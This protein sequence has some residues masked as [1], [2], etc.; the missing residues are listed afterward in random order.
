MSISFSK[1]IIFCLF[2]ALCSLQLMAQEPPYERHF[3]DDFKS[4]YSSRK[5]NYEGDINV[6]NELRPT[7]GKFSEYKDM[8]PK[9]REENNSNSVQ[10]GGNVLTWIFV[11]ILIIAVIYVVYNVMDE[12]Q[13]GFFSRGKFRKINSQEINVNN[14]EETDLQALITSAEDQGD[15]RLAV[16]YQ[17]LM[18]LKTLSVKNAIKYEDDKTDSDYLNEIG[19]KP[20]SSSF[21]KTAYLYNYVWYGEFLLNQQ[22]YGKAKNSFETFLKSVR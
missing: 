16:R 7:D 14:I 11:I 18:V 22:Q 4:R 10:V 6:E 5:Y 1:H 17:Y 9:E 2:L 13:G 19:L 12:G 20:Y 15:F 8:K 21:A 3:D